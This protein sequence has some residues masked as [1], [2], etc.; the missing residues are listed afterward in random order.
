M[1]RTNSKSVA[2]AAVAPVPRRRWR[3]LL[4]GDQVDI[5]A[6]ASRCSR[7][8]L[9]A[10]LE[11]LRRWGL[12]PRLPESVFGDAPFTSNT[13]AQRWRQ[14]CAALKA[15]DSAALW[16]LRGGYGSA[17]MLSH[18]ARMPRPHVVKPIIGFSDITALLY[19]VNTAWGWDV[20]H[21]PVVAQL[22]VNRLARAD[23]RTLRDLLLGQ[24]DT[25]SLRGLRAVNDAAKN[26]AGRKI[27]G[28][29]HAGNLATYMS[30]CGSAATPRFGGR[31][32]VLED[33]NERGY[34][35]DRYLFTLL[36][37]S[38]FA[39]ARAVVFG[40]FLGGE[41]ADGKS[42][43]ND[44]LRAF[45]ARVRCPVF[46]G[47]PVGHGRRLAPLTVGAPAT[48]VATERGRFAFEV[49]R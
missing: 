41:E 7:E 39:R 11:V 9:E 20:I 35:V 46:M 25:V 17:H 45:A 13:E 26:L 30:L 33:V 38:A 43:V 42:R 31:I 10:G 48:I 27:A 8:D 3:A 37:S 28:R 6:P 1:A 34:Q 18:L 14:L 2:A 47:L 24:A 32:V 44:A 16:C 22:G 40:Q 15:P 49:T 23:L 36:Q 21:G 4:P 29:L 12:K 5:V 19:S